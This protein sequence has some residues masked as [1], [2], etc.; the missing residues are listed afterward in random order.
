MS[1]NACSCSSKQNILWLIH[2]NSAKIK[3]LTDLACMM[4]TLE[5]DADH[6]MCIVVSTFEVCLSVKFYFK[7]FLSCVKVVLFIFI[8]NSKFTNRSV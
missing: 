4:K 8:V 7:L 6:L 3:S 2:Q 5:S 1:Y